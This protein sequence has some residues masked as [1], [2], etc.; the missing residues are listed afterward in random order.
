MKVCQPIENFA[1]ND[2]GEWTGDEL[3]DVLTFS[4]Q[5]YNRMKKDPSNP[6]GAGIELDK[7]KAEVDELG[8]TVYKYKKED[9]NLV[10]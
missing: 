6:F 1:Y 5:E 2:R 4:E 10:F 7:W 3:E 8:N 9:L